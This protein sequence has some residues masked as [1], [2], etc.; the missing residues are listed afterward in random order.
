MPDKQI[1]DY[2]RDYC[3]GESRAVTSRELGTVFGLRSREL[4][5][6]ANRLHC[7][8]VPICSSEYGYF[9]AGNEQ[10]PSRTIRQL[11]SRIKKI[12]AAR[13]SLISA[14]ALYTDDGQISLPLGGGD[15]P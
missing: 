15:S 7:A 4:R 13:C 2:L 8:G 1:A 3:R 12:A 14:Q 9:F 10:E 11:I 5:K 6:I